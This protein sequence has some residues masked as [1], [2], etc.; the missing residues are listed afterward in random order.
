MK[1]T[2][3]IILLCVFASGMCT[4]NL[5]KTIDLSNHFH[6][7]TAL[8]VGGHVIGWLVLPQLATAVLICSKDKY[9]VQ[10]SFA[11][12]AAE[13]REESNY[14]Y[15]NP[16]VYMIHAPKGLYFWSNQVTGSEVVVGNNTKGTLL[17][18]SA[19]DFPEYDEYMF[20]RGTYCLRRLNTKSRK[21]Y[22]W[23]ESTAAQHPF[24]LNKN[25][26]CEHFFYARP[27][28][29]VRVISNLDGKQLRLFEVKKT[30]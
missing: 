9:F 4:Y 6:Y 10:R 22:E 21:K 2:K 30:K 5:A 27:E 17:R 24:I 12:H 28:V 25:G 13:T 1:I 11:P 16:D 8:W 19:K 20:I 26:T 29:K 15:I 18:P 3:K 23:N 7:R 14:Y